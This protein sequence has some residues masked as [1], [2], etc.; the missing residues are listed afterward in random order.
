MNG[1]A[2]VVAVIPINVLLFSPKKEMAAEMTAIEFFRLTS[3]LALTAE[4]VPKP[5]PVYPAELRSF[6]IDAQTMF[7]AIQE[8]ILTVFKL[9][10]S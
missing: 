7:T 4:I 1:V 10:K 2:E 5:F 6:F 8:L 9:C 3:I